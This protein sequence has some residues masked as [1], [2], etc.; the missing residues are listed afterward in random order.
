MTALHERGATVSAGRSSPTRQ[1]EQ[2]PVS[3]VFCLAY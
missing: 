3:A 1:R 2:N